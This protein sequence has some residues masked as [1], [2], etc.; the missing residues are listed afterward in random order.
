MK[1]YELLVAEL[2]SVMN[3]SQEDLAKLL[4]VSSITVS[5]WE[6]GH[7]KPKKI[8]QIR[9]DKLLER[10]DIKKEEHIND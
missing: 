8:I 3:V 9:I 1:N 7:S 6:N 5:R 10:Y 4:G 2:R